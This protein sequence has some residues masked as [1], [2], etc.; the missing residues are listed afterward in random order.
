M[1]AKNRIIGC[2]SVTLRILKSK[3]CIM[4]KK[5]SEMQFPRCS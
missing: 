5:M 2:K 4:N 1:G 3:I